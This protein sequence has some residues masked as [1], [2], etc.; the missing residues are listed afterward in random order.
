MSDS[1][2]GPA[3]CAPV[4]LGGGAPLRHWLA[5]GRAR[6]RQNWQNC[7]RITQSDP[8]TVVP[9]RRALMSSSCLEA[10]VVRLVALLTRA[11][12]NRLAHALNG[13]TACL[14]AGGLHP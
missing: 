1:T 10:E 11:E 2:L 6:V 13:N 7:V 4:L 5:Q 12:R 14:G 9:C 8:V 3:A